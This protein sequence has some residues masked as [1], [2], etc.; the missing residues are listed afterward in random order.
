MSGLKK[1]DTKTW[2]IQICLFNSVFWQPAELASNLNEDH[3][4]SCLFK[5]FYHI[6]NI[7]QMLLAFCYRYIFH[8]SSLHFILW[9]LHSPVFI[10]WHKKS[11]GC[12]MKQEGTPKPPR[13]LLC[14]KKKKKKKRIKICVPLQREREKKIL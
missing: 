6:L 13:V 7:L 14:H 1:L 5:H 2:D 10:L 9:P 12:H 4:R 11:E 8:F 3:D